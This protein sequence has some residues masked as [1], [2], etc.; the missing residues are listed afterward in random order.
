MALASL[1]GA[2]DRIDWKN[3]VESDEIERR[4][5]EDFKRAFRA[6]DPFA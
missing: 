2:V 5:A 1:F 6:F 4:Q 3:C